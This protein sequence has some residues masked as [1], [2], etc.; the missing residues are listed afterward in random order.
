MTI[1][2]PDYIPGTKH[3]DP[4]EGVTRQDW[5]RRQNIISDLDT[6]R[7]FHNRVGMWWTSDDFVACDH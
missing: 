7:Q 6:V 5:E 1:D 3:E 4:R 2:Y